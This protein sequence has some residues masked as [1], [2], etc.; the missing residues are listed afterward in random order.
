MSCILGIDYGEKRIGV[1][2]AD[3]S[4]K[5]PLPHKTIKVKKEE[6]AV[7]EIVNI[8]IENNV[9][10]LVIG[11]PE[12]DQSKKITKKIQNFA[13]KIQSQEYVDIEFINEDF[14]SSY[15]K[16]LIEEQRA[17]GRK[18]KVKKEEIDRIAAT[19]ILQS[20][21]ENEL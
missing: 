15:A 9:K 6:T 3:L 13:N 18:K 2:I 1:S 17:A 19:L 20:F 4:T 16:S 12:S 8:I 14:T 11:L 21:L 7:K 10:T 5:I